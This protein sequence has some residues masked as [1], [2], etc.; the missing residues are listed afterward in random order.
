MGPCGRSENKN[1]AQDQR[2]VIATPVTD[3]TGVAIPWM[4]VGTDRLEASPLLL[5]R[6]DRAK[7]GTG[8]EGTRNDNICVT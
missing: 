2:C 5:E 1:L 8:V 7:P 6:V 3:I 4:N